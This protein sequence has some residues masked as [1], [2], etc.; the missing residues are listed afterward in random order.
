MRVLPAWINLPFMPPILA[1]LGV[2]VASLA[3]A[4]GLGWLIAWLTRKAL[5]T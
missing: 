1:F 2:L 5:R 4:F 3:A